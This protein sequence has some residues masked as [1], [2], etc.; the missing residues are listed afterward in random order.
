[1]QPGLVSS[2][3]GSHTRDQFVDSFVVADEWVLAQHRALCLIVELKMYPVDSE[4]STPL[5]CMPNELPAQ[6]RSS[7]LWCGVN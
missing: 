5:L 6:A 3:L 2:V 1:M 7:C 4:V